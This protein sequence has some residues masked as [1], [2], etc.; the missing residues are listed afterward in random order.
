MGDNGRRMMMALAIL[1]WFAGPGAAQP[2][3]EPPGAPPP[4][5][6]PA[7]QTGSPRE[8]PRFET[9][10]ELVLVDVTVVSN[11]GEPVA[12]LE[13]GDFK[14]TVNGQ[15]RPVNTVQYVTSRGAKVPEST[16]RLAGSSSNDGPTTGRLLLFVIDENYLRVGAGRAVLRAAERVMS[17]LA[18]GDLV[19]LARLPSGRGSVN[20]TTDRARIRRALSGVIGSQPPRSTENV[21]LSEAHAFDSRDATVWDQVIERECPSA[22][23]GVGSGLGREACINE[24]EAQARNLLTDAGARTRMSIGALEGLAERLKSAGAPVNIIMLSEGLYLGRDRGD[25]NQLARLAADARLT[26]YV[27]QPDESLFDFDKPQTVGGFMSESALAEGLEHLAGITRGAYF[28]VAGS[29]EG[30]FDRISRELSGYYL[31]SFEPTDADRQSRDRRIRVEVIRRGLTVKSRSTYALSRPSAATR[32]DLAPEAHV[33]ELLAAPLPTGG[34]PIRVAT[35][36][37]TSDEDNRVR[38]V[39]A[40]EIGEPATGPAEWPVGVLVFN[41]ADRVFVDSTR[42]MTLEPATDRAPSPRLLT[43]TM[44]LDP[45]EYSLRLAAIDHDG[46]S[47]SVHHLLD[48]RLTPLAGNAIR[49]SDLIVS[50]DLAPGG[51]PRPLPTAVQYSE[52]LYSLLEIAGS[53]TARIAKTRVRLEIADSESAKPLVAADAQPFERAPGQRTYASLL[54][55]GLLPPGEYVARAVVTVPGQDDAVITRAFRLAPVAAAADASPIAAR[56]DADEAPAPLP[57]AKI[58]APIVRFAVDDVLR[59]EA[60]RPYLDFLQRE[61]PASP[62]A[63]AFV[64]QARGGTFVDVPTDLKVP[65][66]DDVTLAFVRGLAQLQKKQYTQAAAWFQL[67]LKGA[68]DFL[69]AAFYLGA[70]HA[71]SGRDHDAI[72]AWQ[73]ATIGDDPEPVYPPLV[74]ALL[75]IGDAQAALELIAEAPQAWPSDD[76]RL[77]RVATAQAMLGQF[78]PA[79]EILPG[80]VERQPADLDVLFVTVQ[81]LYRQ[82]LARP[83]AAEDRAR[84]DAYCQRY[85]DANGPESALVVAWRRYVM[86]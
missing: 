84:F 34:L 32:T 31:L 63:Q 82:H 35:Y 43:M 21:R 70:V 48:A 40:A 59:V 6:P 61:H 75:R 15:V 8:Q 58:A 56:V 77:K 5:P 45:G 25:L 10:A 71:A 7:G 55:L 9:S 23:V 85:L 79:L 18:E 67:A 3:A 74:D 13:A 24:L 50:S 28:K 86:Q 46:R 83:L 20:F 36:S 57:M 33:K 64:Q 53:D 1:A 19:G 29:G 54:K 47:G 22:G 73:M 11:T 49:A 37:V 78:A 30:I 65:P 2:P 16:P 27:V 76:A 14:L 52:T 69:G 44:V 39:L 12:G 4:S 62:A 41:N 51:T 26:F 68:S 72:G 66:S 38:V 81:V 17:T 42:Y 60:V 80:L